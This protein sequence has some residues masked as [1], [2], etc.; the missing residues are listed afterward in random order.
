LV[1]VGQRN[2][3]TAEILSGIQENDK[4]IAHPDDAISDGSRIQSRK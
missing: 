2:G 1:E 4:V 3:F